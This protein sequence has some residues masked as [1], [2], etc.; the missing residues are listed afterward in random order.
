MTGPTHDRA[1]GDLG[2]GSPRVHKDLRESP[3]SE[4]ETAA[5]QR[6]TDGAADLPP[7]TGGP[8]DSGDAP[9]RSDAAEVRPEPDPGQD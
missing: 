6:D 1:P 8:D 2:L 5:K 4:R 3:A 7:G 9:L